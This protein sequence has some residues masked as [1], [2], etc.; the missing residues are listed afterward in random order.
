MPKFLHKIPFLGGLLKKFSKRKKKDD[1]DD[2]WY[3]LY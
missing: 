1:E 2:A 3:P